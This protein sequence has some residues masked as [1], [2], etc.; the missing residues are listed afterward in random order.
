MSGKGIFD[1][2]LEF[3]DPKDFADHL[4]SLGMDVPEGATAWVTGYD[5]GTAHS[6]TML[7]IERLDIPE[8]DPNGPLVHEQVVELKAPPTHFLVSGRQ[9][10]K[11]DLVNLWLSPYIDCYF[12]TLRL[13]EHL[14]EG[15]WYR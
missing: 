11:L 10:G 6:V 9:T 15:F 2:V 7:Q 3:N 4:R 12:G 14:F 5:M 1:N 13:L 8:P